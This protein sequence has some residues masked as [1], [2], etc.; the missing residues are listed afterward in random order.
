MFGFIG[1]LLFLLAFQSLRSLTATRWQPPSW[2][3]TP[4]WSTSSECWPRTA[5]EWESPAPCLSGPGQR[6]QV[7]ASRQDVVS[8]AD[9]LWCWGVKRALCCAVPDAAPG[10]VG[11]G[12]GSRSELVITWEVIHPSHVGVSFI[13]RFIPL[14]FTSASAF[15][16]ESKPLP[17]AAPTGSRLPPYILG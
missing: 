2:T 6:T 11:G 17:P 10:D 16:P 12:G 4:G 7:R 8:A 3:S 15:L 13:S 1:I 5:W 9:C 14:I